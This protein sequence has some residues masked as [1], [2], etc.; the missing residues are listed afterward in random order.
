MK[1]RDKTNRN[2]REFG[3][4]EFIKKVSLGAAGMGMLAGEIS[5]SGLN[6]FGRNRGKNLETSQMRYRRLG[7]TEVMVSE[8]GLGGHYDGPKWQEKK[9]KEQWQREA[10]FKESLKNGINFFDTNTEYERESLGKILG[11]IPDLREKIYIVTDVND[12]KKSGTE[13]FDYMMEIIDVQLCALQLSS[14]DILRFTTVIKKTPSERLEAAFKAFHKMKKDGKVKYLALSQHDPEL[15]TKW[16]NKYDEIDIIYVPYNYFAPRAEDEL[17]DAAKKKDMGIIIIKPFNKGT[18]FN[19]EL[20][21]LIEGSGSRSILDRV[22]KEKEQ[23]T[24]ESLIQGTNLTLAQASLSYIL[25]N[26]SVSTVIPGMETIEEVRENVSIV[27][28]KFGNLERSLLE[29]YAT[30]NTDKLPPNYRWLNHWCH[31]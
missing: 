23:R 4:R 10:V 5:C 14:V 3:R 11:T 15:L 20:A 7:R 2:G 26:E 28:S 18:I 25:A 1:N 9:S 8:I 17:F 6:V 19:P 30:K 21:D 16:V 24:P 31:T 12:L 29:K 27:G 13:T 22:E